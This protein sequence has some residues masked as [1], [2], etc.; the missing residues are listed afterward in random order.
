MIIISRMKTFSIIIIYNH[1]HGDESILGS[2]GLRRNHLQITARNCMIWGENAEGR[3][4]GAQQGEAEDWR[5][6]EIDR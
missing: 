5:Q 4:L 3:E 6:D 2:L 1:L